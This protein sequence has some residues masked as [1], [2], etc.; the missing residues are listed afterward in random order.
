M[1]DDRIPP[2]L[3]VGCGRM[4]S[5]ML[6]GWRE[7]GLA[8]SVAVDPA[9]AALAQAGPDLQVV[10]EPAAI[11]SGF[12]PEA[13]V[14]AVKPQNAATTLPD[15]AGFGGLSVFLSIM[16]GRTISGIRAMVGT[17]AAIVR[18]MPNTPAAGTA[19][20]DRCLPRY[21]RRA[22]PAR[23]MRVAAAGHRHRRLGG[24]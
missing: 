21:R 20:R 19:G 23:P 10:A 24:Q 5:A 7:R 9:P 14:F 11:P 17:D 22:S 13:V 4:G 8:P 6:A 12:T 15:Y 3:L 18:A 1:S 16:A 2:I